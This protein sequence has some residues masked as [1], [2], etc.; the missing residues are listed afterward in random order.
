MA[1]ATDIRIILA[2]ARS[3][4]GQGRAF[5]AAVLVLEDPRLVGQLV[6]CLWDED[7]VIAGRASNALETVVAE[8][9]RIVA[10]YKEALLGLLA[11]A[12]PIKLRWHLALTVTGMKLSRSECGRVAE[13]LNSWLDHRSSIVKTCAMQGLA[14]LTLQDPSLNDGVL[15]LIRTLSRSGTPAMRARGRALV[16]Q[17]EMGKRPTW[18]RVKQQARSVARLINCP[19]KVLHR[20]AHG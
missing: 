4:K 11:E 12:G 19:R 1:K 20:K 17:L 14:E 16:N 15:D 5:D 9:P 3:G 6:A 7:D 8:S 2:D 10:R 13:I 18:V